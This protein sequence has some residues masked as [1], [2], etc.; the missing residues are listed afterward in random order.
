MGRR[1]GKVRGQKK[2]GR[3]EEEVPISKSPIRVLTNRTHFENVKWSLSDVRPL[4]TRYDICANI[5][6]IVEVKVE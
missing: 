2:E 1:D 5:F 3:G 6:S 4:L